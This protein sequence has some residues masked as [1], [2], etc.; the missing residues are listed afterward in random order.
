MTEFPAPDTRP[1]PGGDPAAAGLPV[2]TGDTAADLDPGDADTPEGG[3]IARAGDEPLVAATRRRLA[4]LDG[5]PV[6]S[7]V[8]VYDELHGSLQGALAGLDEG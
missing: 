6:A 4:E 1:H 8:A 7:H 2:P 5:T 3:E